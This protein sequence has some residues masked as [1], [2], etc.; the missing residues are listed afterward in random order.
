MHDMGWFAILARVLIVAAVVWATYIVYRNHQEATIQKGVIWGS[1]VLVVAIGLAF[2]PPL[3][4]QLWERQ[5]RKKAE[6]A[7][8]VARQSQAFVQEKR[9]RQVRLQECRTR[10][11]E[12]QDRLRFAQARLDELRRDLT[13]SNHRGN[14][15]Q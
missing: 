9:E 5:A 13:G 10:K 12:L 6:V 11:S 3:A 7:A 4:D 2:A 15:A 8:Q 14:D 1:V